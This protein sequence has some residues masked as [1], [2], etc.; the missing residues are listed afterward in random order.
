M[1][2]V[3]KKNIPPEKGGLNLGL[4][5]LLC[6]DISFLSFKYDIFVKKKFKIKIYNNTIKKFS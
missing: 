6:F 1:K 4:I 3:I 5:K 2:T